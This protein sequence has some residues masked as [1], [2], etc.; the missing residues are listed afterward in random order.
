LEA[1]LV[2]SDLGVKMSSSL[3]EHLKEELKSGRE[4]SEGDFFAII[5]ERLIEVLTEGNTGPY[6]INIAVSKKKLA[7]GT[8]VIIMLVGVN[9]AGKT[10]TAAKLAEKF[11]NQ[12]Y[13]VMLAAADTFRAAAVEQLR[14]WGFKISVP[15]IFGPPESKPATVVYDAVVAA[16][17]AA[18][19]VLIIDTAGRLHT[20]SNLMQELTGVKN[21]ISR[22]IPD[23]PHETILVVD[24]STGQ[25]AL[26]QAE[27]FNEAIPLTGLVVTKLDGTSKGGI[28]VAIKDKLSIP[29]KYIGVG[30]SEADLRDFDPQEFVDALFDT[31]EDKENDVYSLTDVEQ[32]AHSEV[33]RRRRQV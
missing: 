14:S 19:D 21:S 4:V 28:V 29:V 33:R 1:Q 2:G 6:G 11:K 22:H 18:A 27:Q 7:P 20:K 24:G 8:P 25:N 23:G 17:K 31:S 15:V 32:S 13:K 9:G 10:T 3:I 30:E 12:R 5:K 16:K 26:S